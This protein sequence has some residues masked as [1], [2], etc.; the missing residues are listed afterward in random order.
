EFLDTRSILAGTD[1]LTTITE[2]LFMDISS[3]RELQVLQGPI[4]NKT[5]LENLLTAMFYTMVPHFLNPI[6]YSLRN[7]QINTALCKM[8]KSYFEK[9]HN[10]YLQ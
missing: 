7:R 9:T 1:N 8:Y 6:I 5:S 4:A 3:S 2:F 10:N